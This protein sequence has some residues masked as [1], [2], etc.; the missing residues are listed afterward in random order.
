ME[1]IPDKERDIYINPIGST[2][3][4]V[5]NFAKPGILRNNMA[6]LLCSL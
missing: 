6:A 1:H 5:L 3:P 2:D 4:N